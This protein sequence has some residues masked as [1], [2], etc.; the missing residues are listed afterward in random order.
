MNFIKTKI[1]DIIICEPKVHEDERGY[2][3]ESFKKESFE[4]FIG[5]AVNFCQDNEAKSTKGVLRGLHYQLPPFAQ[6]KLVRVI[7]GSVLD[8]AVDIRKKS[9]TF[10]KYVAVELSE[11]NKKQ[12]FVPQG[13]AH[14]YVVLSKE[15]IFAYKVDNY[16]NKSSERGIL[17]NDKMLQIDWQLSEDEILISEK[18]KVQK[19]FNEAD[20]F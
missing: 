1:S 19:S 2:F 15:A 17:F 11:T 16:Y 5:H 12:L 7:K 6:S 8:I 18:D 20:Y 14:G 10:G 9:K 4:K 13:F 3:F